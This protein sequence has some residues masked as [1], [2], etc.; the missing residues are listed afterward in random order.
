VRFI[1]GSPS[2][3]GLVYLHARFWAVRSQ[4]SAS[5]SKN[6]GDDAMKS[7]G[8]RCPR[9]TC[10][11]IHDKGVLGCGSPL[12]IWV[13]A[14]VVGQSFLLHSGYRGDSESDRSVNLTNTCDLRALLVLELPTVPANMDSVALPENGR[15]A[16]AKTYNFST[17]ITAMVCA[18]GIVVLAVVGVLIRHVSR[19]WRAVQ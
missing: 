16:R 4:T 7:L 12:V 18:G 9:R 10:T 6:A 13:V 15:A 19:P 14:Q 3:T 17:V 8:T 11:S 5:P 1:C 2:K